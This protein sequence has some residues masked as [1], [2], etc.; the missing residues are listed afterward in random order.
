MV[1]GTK[2]ESVI[3]METPVREPRNGGKLIKDMK[4]IRYSH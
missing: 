3:I 1:T 2:M 4:L